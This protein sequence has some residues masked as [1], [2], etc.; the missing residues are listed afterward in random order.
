[1]NG[2][3]LKHAPV[4]LFAGTLLAI[5]TGLVIY[6]PTLYQMFC[7]LTGLAGTVQRGPPPA[8]RTTSND[9][10]TVHFDA[11]VASGLAWDFAPEQREVTVHFN[12]PTQVYYQAKNN[13]DHT[14]VARA[15]FNVTPYQV[16]PYFFKI[17]CFCFTNEKLEPGESARM[18]LVLYVDE[19]MLNDMDTKLLHDITLSYTF[20]EQKNLPTD[21]VA[22]TRSLKAGSQSTDAKL[23]ETESTNFENDAPRG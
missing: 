5:M 7:S 2:N 13:T 22:A 15:V 18:P 14:V 1:M 23:K 20:Y 12:E 8:T 3:R 16:A 21:E 11:N 9:T 4:L 6:S 10:V 19:Q 17:Q